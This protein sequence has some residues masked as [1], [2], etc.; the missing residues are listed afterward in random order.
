MNLSKRAEKFIII[1]L[2]LLAFGLRTYRL[3]AQ[4]YWIDEAWTVYF[5]HLSI[6]QVW[7]ALQSQEFMPPFYFPTA[8]YWVKLVGDS[9][10]GLRF[11][12]TLF[13]VLAI[14]FT[15]RLGE[16]LGD[17]RLGLL[18]ALLMTCAPYQIWHSQDARMYAV[19]TAASA[20]SMWGFV[21]F[22]KEGGWRG[23]LIYVI[24]TLW[25]LLIHYHGLLLVGIQGLFL[26][27]T[28]RRHW[29]RYLAWGG[30]LLV[31]ALLYTPWLVFGSVFARSFR[32]W[33]IQQPTLWEALLRSARAYSVGELVPPAQAIPLAAAFVVLYGVGLVYAVRRGWGAWRGAYVGGLL[34]LYTLVPILVAWLYGEFSAT[35]YYERYLILVQPGYLLAAAL[36]IVAVAD[37]LRRRLAWEA[38]ILAGVVALLPLG[39]DGWVLSHHYFDPTY[40]KPDWRATARTVESYGL[41]GDAVVI[42]GDGSEKAFGFYYRGDL[43]VY[44]DFN[45]P[46]PPVDKARQIIADIA[47]AHRRIWY[48]PYGLDIDATL[49]DWLAQN[50][51]PAWQSWLARNRLMLVGGSTAPI[52]RRE[53]LNASFADPAGRGP[54]LVSVAL[55]AADTAAGD[56]LPLALTWQ[57]ASRLEHDYQVSLRLSNSRGDVFV[58]SDWPPL[59]AS[60]GASAW[61]PGQPVADRRGLWLPAD[62]PPGDY[63]LSIVVYDPASGQP[64]G[65][66]IVVPNIGVKPAQTVVPPDLL[67]IPHPLQ[68]SLGDLT[69]VGYTAPQAIRPGEELWLWLYW[70]AGA[71]GFPEKGSAVRLKLVSGE[72]AASIDFP[73]T[74]SVGP[75]DGWRPGQ[76]RRAIYHLPTSPRLAGKQAE[77]GV[78]L[79]SAQGQVEGQMAVAQ[80]G[81]AQRPRRF[82]APS[83]SHKTDIA[84]GNPVLLKLIGYHLPAP[85]VA[86]GQALPVTLYWQAEATMDIN[87]T[88]FVQL[89][90]SSGQVSAQRDLQPQAG[91]APTVTWLPGEILT[92]AYTLSLSSDLSPGD[93]RLIAG[94]YN[95]ANGERLPVSSPAGGN[96][97]D[98]G[99]VTIR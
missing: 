77:I 49:E 70:Q 43:P 69:L 81:L 63:A 1:G 51:Y 3:A 67:A 88:V 25:M 35:L 62:L 42:T 90:N 7:H 53:T 13:G 37:G 83:I 36:G 89:L 97:V 61:Q 65:Q 66:P 22:W 40:A 23:W 71:G 57:T 11:Y 48:A 55:P 91:A 56:V 20:M 16:A 21:R 59:A 74:D 82:E 73:L 99:T 44:T 39:V 24:G 76:V 14:P 33:W 29:R 45:T 78:A 15:Y 12:S 26:L 98:L 41:P 34:L 18:A 60:R 27:M 47:A 2:T 92:D 4:S 46:V 79:L 85:T 93:Y 68:Q 10:F 32:S 38:T 9:E 52:D 30:T 19:L 5:A 84:L 96:F 80:V 28:W 75:L 6:G 58:Q 50:A 64:L 72:E 95:A 8:L 54:A 94:M 86:P 31:V 87:Y 17:R